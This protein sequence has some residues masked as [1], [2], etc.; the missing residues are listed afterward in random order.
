MAQIA[1]SMHRATPSGVSS[2]LP[3]TRARAR[4]PRAA[5]AAC[6]WALR[7]R[8][9]WRRAAFASRRPASSCSRARLAVVLRLV[10]MRR[11]SARRRWPPAVVEVLVACAG[12]GASRAAPRSR[13]RIVGVLRC[14]ERVVVL[15]HCVCT[16]LTVR[17]LF[18]ARRARAATRD[19]M[20][21]GWLTAQISARTGASV[22]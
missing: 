7:G 15:C 11:R 22:P 21:Y 17:V 6:S 1:S 13:E 20:P 12:A 3:R 8:R 18:S 4:P 14:G 16:L 2:V 19:H 10:L 5:A 9:R